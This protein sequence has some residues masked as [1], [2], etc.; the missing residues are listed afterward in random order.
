LQVPL[1]T[2]PLPGK[3]K[4]V[5][6]SG[7]S[8]YTPY[9]Q[10]TYTMVDERKSRF[11]EMRAEA[12]SFI[13]GGQNCDYCEA[14]TSSAHPASNIVD[15]TALWWQSP[16]LS[17]GMAYSEVNIT[18]DLEQVARG[19]VYLITHMCDFSSLF[20]SPMFGCKWPT[21]H[22]RVCLV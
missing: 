6:P 22:G 17:R 9:N 16:P 19:M 12:G 15:G 1:S 13:Q 18:F 20:T 21:V 5:V 10:Y 14:N 8:P 4:N 3:H 11:R 2:N 7:A